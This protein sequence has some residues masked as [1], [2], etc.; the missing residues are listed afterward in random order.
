[1]SQFLSLLKPT[2][3]TYTKATFFTSFYILRHFTFYIL[4]LKNRPKTH[5]FDT[6]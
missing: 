6:L 1:V 4:P 5:F 2:S 3:Q